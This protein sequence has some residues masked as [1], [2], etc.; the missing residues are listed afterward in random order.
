MSPHVATQLERALFTLS[1]T[2]Y[3]SYSAMENAIQID[4]LYLCNTLLYLHSLLS[5]PEMNGIHRDHLKVVAHNEFLEPTKKSLMNMD[6]KVGR[7]IKCLPAVQDEQHQVLRTRET[8]KHL[9]RVSA[10][11][12]LQ[13]VRNTYDLAKVYHQKAFFF[14]RVD[15]DPK[16]LNMDCRRA[17]SF[18]SH[19]PSEGPIHLSQQLPQETVPSCF[20]LGRVMPL[21]FQWMNSLPLGW[22]KKKRSVL[23]FVVRFVCRKR[24]LIHRP[25]DNIVHASFLLSKRSHFFVGFIL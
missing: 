14:L 12:L 25:A 19:L 11:R 9:T 8:A 4:I 20:M 16:K 21:L 6:L 5:V 1:N 3:Y 24:A 17:A 7:T 23:F 22:A 2:R 13:N 18:T 15:C 10:I